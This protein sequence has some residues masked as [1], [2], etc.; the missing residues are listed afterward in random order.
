MRV[1]RASILTVSIVLA[2]ATAVAGQRGVAGSQQQARPFRHAAHTRLACAECHPTGE[3]HRT[4]R[5]WTPADC[6]ACHHNPRR[7]YSCTSCHE[8][9]AITGARTVPARVSLTVWR[10]A[11]VRDLPFDHETHAARLCVDCHGP[12]VTPE[13]CASCHAEHHVPEADCTGCHPPTETGVH[14]LR[15]HLTCTGAGCHSL[16]SGDRPPLSRTLCLLCHREQTDHEPA[17]TCH[18]CHRI[19]GS[20]PFPGSAGR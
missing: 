20:E 6:A 13:T 10:D 9:A 14:P 18:A 12:T 4:P 16:E 3:R 17:G 2:A 1:G 5:V 19:P 7:E 11:R 8:S 15:S